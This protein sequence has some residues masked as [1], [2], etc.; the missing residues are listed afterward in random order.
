MREWMPIETAPKDERAV[1]LWQ[2]SFNRRLTNMSRVE[3]TE[4]NVFYAPV[5]NGPSCVR[6]ASHW[7]PLP[8]PPK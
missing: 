4:N 8:E 2:S 1:D 5:E 7:M 6:D 3:L